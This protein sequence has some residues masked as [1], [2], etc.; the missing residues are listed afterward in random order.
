MFSLKNWIMIVLTLI[1]VFLYTAALLGW[2]K[3]L[4]DI[5]LVMRLEPILFVILGYYFSSLPAQQTQT[6]LKE[7]IAR[8]TKR[9][10]AAQY[11]REQSQQERDALEEKLKNVRTVLMP[12][13]GKRLSKTLIDSSFKTDKE[14]NS[15]ALQYSISAALNILNS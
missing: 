9:A 10:D 2:L 4:S 5:T 12:A 8:Q 15:E 14:N 7:E 1:F 6:A 13:A 11:S 3:P